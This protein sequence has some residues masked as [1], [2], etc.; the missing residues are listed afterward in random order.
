M[1]PNQPTKRITQ[2]KCWQLQEK[3]ILKQASRPCPAMSP[4]AQQRAML[5]VLRVETGQINLHIIW[6]SQAWCREIT[7]LCPEV[8]NLVAKSQMQLVEERAEVWQ[9]KPVTSPLLFAS[10]VFRTWVVQDLKDPQESKRG[11]AMSLVRPL[12]NKLLRW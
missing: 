3:V 12:P 7:L 4:Q 5:L 10:L 2:R 1:A 11:S 6:I 9:Q 8:A